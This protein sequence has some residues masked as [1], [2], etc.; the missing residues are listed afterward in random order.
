[1]YYTF[2][3]FYYFL[4]QFQDMSM[5]KG[6]PLLTKVQLPHNIYTLEELIPK[7]NKKIILIL[8]EHPKSH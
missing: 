7:M 2:I 3:F 6:T 8:R 1:M 5:N 4:L